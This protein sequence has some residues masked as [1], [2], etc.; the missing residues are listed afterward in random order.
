MDW[1]R[2]PTDPRVQQ[3]LGWTC[4]ICAARV[5]HLCS[6]TID[7]DRELPG[8]VIHYGRLTDRRRK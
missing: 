1:L 3:A 4:D 5:K 8:R 7:P 6:N 2:D